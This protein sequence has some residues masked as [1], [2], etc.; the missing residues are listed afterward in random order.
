MREVTD[1]EAKAATLSQEVDSLISIRT[2]SE[3]NIRRSLKTLAG[4][5]EELMKLLCKL[6]AVETNVSYG[7][8]PFSMTH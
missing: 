4:A 3:Q 2:D 6:D 1:I 7:C 5:N 8:V